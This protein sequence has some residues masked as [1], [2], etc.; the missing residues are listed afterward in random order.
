MLDPLVKLPPEI[1]QYLSNFFSVR[2]VLNWRRVCRA[3]RDMLLSPALSPF[4]RRASVHAGV[5]SE[6]VRSL[7][8]ECKTV[9]GVFQR[10][11]LYTDH[12][13]RIRPE[14][15]VLKGTYPFES[16]SQCVYAGEGYFVRTLNHQSLGEEETVI[17]ELCPH[18]R[19][20]QKV[21]SVKGSYGKAK[22]A[23]IFAN[24]IVWST[25]EDWWLRFNLEDHTHAEFFDR[26]I[27]KQNGDGV[28]FCRHCLFLVI[29]NSDTIMHDYH[30]K[31]RFIKVEGEEVIETV[32]K[33]TIPRK[34][35]QYAPRPVKPILVSGDG[36]KT[37]RLVVQGGTGACVFDVTHDVEE[38]RVELSNKPLAVLNPFYDLEISV[39]IVTTAS[40]IRLSPD[41]TFV[42]LI[43]SIV[44]PYNTGLCIYAFD[45]RTFERTLVVR[46]R[47]AEGFNDCRLLAVSPLYAVI[48]IEHSDGVVKIIHCRSGEVV[49]SIGPLYNEPPPA[50]GRQKYVSMQGVYGEECL[51]D[52]SGRLSLVV[53]YCRNAG[54]TEA[55]FYDPFPPS[56]ALLE[57]GHRDSDSDNDG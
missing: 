21:A 25:S 16:S 38:M 30:W 7:Q 35:T 28:G 13:A 55:I 19:T 32:H 41:E 47:W 33:P 50:S 42:S 54:N 57:G 43:S 1:I 40:L 26:P 9:D 15:K 23:A 39:M 36:C 53:V 44:Y 34:I 14:T 27:K 22:Y 49:A 45:L 8:P 56:M 18:R 3:W 48:A 17:G 31:L 20:I 29:G 10:A 4:W 52:I 2:D 5:P 46:I 11:R 51:S 37:H 6:C 12:I 24:H